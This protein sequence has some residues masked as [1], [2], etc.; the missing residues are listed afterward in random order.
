MS[1]CAMLNWK[2]KKKLFL[3]NGNIP[4]NILIYKYIRANTECANPDNAERF[5]SLDVV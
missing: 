5:K 2:A 3:S 1:Y 4:Y